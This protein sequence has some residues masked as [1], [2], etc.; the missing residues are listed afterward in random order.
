MADKVKLLLAKARAVGLDRALALLFVALCLLLMIQG[1]RFVGAALSS[2]GMASRVNTGAVAPERT[3]RKPATDYDAILEKGLLGKRE[4]G[5][6]PSGPAP[7]VTVFGIL[8]NKALLGA[9]ANDAKPFAI[10]AEVPGGEKL[11]EIGTAEVVLEKDGNKRTL[12][13]FPSLSAPKST[14]AAAPGATPPGAAPPGISPQ[15]AAPAG[16]PPAT[17]VAGTTPPVA[18]PPVVTPGSAASPAAL[19]PAAPPASAPPSATAPSV[20]AVPVESQ[21]TG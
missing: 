13:V 8:G 11:V 4:K 10:G 19:I 7:A 15:V 6:G 17:P 20:V 3:D 5:G 1:L 14:T 2:R 9:S 16:A 18:S 21:K 12:K